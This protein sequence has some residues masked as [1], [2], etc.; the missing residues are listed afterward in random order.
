MV[1]TVEARG[2]HGNNCGREELSCYRLGK[3]GVICN[4]WRMSVMIG[5]RGF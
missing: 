2:C 4:D 1:T 5:G 3:G